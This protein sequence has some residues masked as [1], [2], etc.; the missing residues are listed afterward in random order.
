MLKPE[1]AD[2]L[3]DYTEGWISALYLCML[4]YLQDG[5]IGRQASLYELIEKVVYREFPDGV[6]EFLFT[7]CIFENF[8]LAQAKFLKKIPKRY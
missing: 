2:K 1:E 6:K 3:Y 4:E 5:R 7:I 8:T